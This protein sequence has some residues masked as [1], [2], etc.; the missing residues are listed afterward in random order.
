[1]RSGRIPHLL[2]TQNQLGG[3]VRTACGCGRSRP[4]VSS[5]QLNGVAPGKMLLSAAAFLARDMVRCRFVI[6][7][8]TQEHRCLGTWGRPTSQITRN[9]TTASAGVNKTV[10]VLLARAS[11]ARQSL[12]GWVTVGR[13]ELQVG[14]HSTA[15]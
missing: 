9:T 10:G 7:G 1:M 2:L 5:S 14:R 3:E 12:G 4:S 13:Q 6:L 11:E 15:S 8:C